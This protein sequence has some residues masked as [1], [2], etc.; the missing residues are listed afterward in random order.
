MTVTIDWK[1]E[2]SYS[3]LDKEHIPR[4]WSCEFEKTVKV[5]IHKH[6]YTGEEWNLS[7]NVL[8][9]DTVSLKTTDLEKAKQRGLYIV[10]KCIAN[11][12]SVFA[13][14][15]REIDE[16]YP[17]EKETT[18]RDE[19]IQD[20]A[21]QPPPSQANTDVPFRDGVRHGE[22]LFEE[23]PDGYYH[24]E[25]SVCGKQDKEAAYL[26]KWKYC[27]HC[28]ACMDGRREDGNE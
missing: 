27:P 9:L 8:N 22:W 4:V 21:Q 18:N 26:E 3:R 24:S 19:T 1:D 10:R 2:T 5:V 28:G 14:I 20:R 11:M 12:E 16:V 7:C 25:C 23:Y 15:V 17:H 6:I 13:L